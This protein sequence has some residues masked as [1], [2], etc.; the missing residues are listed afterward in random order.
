ML[1]SLDL[2]HLPAEHN[3]DSALVA[4]IHGDLVGVGETV[5]LF[6]GGPV[7]DSSTGRGSSLELVLSHEMLVKE[8]VEIGSLALVGELG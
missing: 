3:I 6:V 7:L 8:S 5:D 2:K 1:V 4:L